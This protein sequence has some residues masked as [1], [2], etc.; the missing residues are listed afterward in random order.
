MVAKS[1]GP[2]TCVITASITSGPYHTQQKLCPISSPGMTPGCASLGLL[3]KVPGVHRFV[4]L[5][6][7]P[8]YV[9]MATEDGCRW[10]LPPQS[11]VSHHL[12]H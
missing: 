10:P 2:T 6:K 8:P 4:W 11:V 7:S 12:G 9:K 3:W 5:S 1:W